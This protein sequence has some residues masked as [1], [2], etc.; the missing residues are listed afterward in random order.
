MKL[1][2]RPIATWPGERSRSRQPSNFS[3]HWSETLATLEREVDMI[4]NRGRNTE[5][6]IQLAVPEGAIRQDGQ[7]KGGRS[8]PAHPGVIISFESK[9]GPLQFACDRFD[10][11]GADPWRHNVRAIALGLEALRKIDRYGI[12]SGTEQYTG[13]QALPPGTPM[14]G[15]MTFEEACELMAIAL[16]RAGAVLEL[17]NGTLDPNEAWRTASKVHHPDAGGD[18]EQFIRLTEA[19]DLIEGVHSTRGAGR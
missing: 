18:P 10:A 5:A 4:G 9:T 17:L 6:V 16:G 8:R 13:F 14:P 19:R 3:A 12:G 15:A 11:S 1:L 7:L 2:Y